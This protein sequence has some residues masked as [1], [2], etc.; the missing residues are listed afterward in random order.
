MHDNFERCLAVTWSPQDDGQPFHCT[1]GDP[2]GDT[3]WGIT[4]ASLSHYLGRQATPDDLRAM[5]LATRTA[6]YATGYWPP[7]E[8]LPMGVDLMVFD[9]G[10]VDGP[11]TSARV[12]QKA[13][14]LVDEDVDGWIGPQTLALVAAIPVRQLIT[15]VAISQ[16]AHVRTLNPKFRNGWDNRIARDVGIAES[17]IGPGSMP[18]P[19]P[20]MTMTTPQPSA[21]QLMAA[22]QKQLDGA[23]T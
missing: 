2:G 16:H 8:K 14:G 11:G 10:V 3:A 13:V 1:A 15:S 7:A 6:V 19:G 18:A 23:S 4:L 21:D 5:T 9:F 22:E 12:L 17:W 20:T